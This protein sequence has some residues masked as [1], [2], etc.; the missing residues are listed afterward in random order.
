LT[1]SSWHLPCQGTQRATRKVDELV[2]RHAIVLTAGLMEAARSSSYLPWQVRVIRPPSLEELV[3]GKTHEE[4]LEDVPEGAEV[5][6]E[7]GLTYV[8]SLVK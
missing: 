8:Y 2:V 5:P 1:I 7:P 6:Y 4:E 3:C